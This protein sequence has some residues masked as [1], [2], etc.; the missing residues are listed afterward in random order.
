ME[1]SRQLETN[2]YRYADGQK[3]SVDVLRG[4]QKLTTSVEV[5]KREDDPMRF[6]DLVDPLKNLVPKLGI[7]G[8]AIDQKLAALLPD[9]RNPYGIVVAA[10]AGDSH[11][12]G[13]TLSPGDV[14]YSVNTVAVTSIDTLNKAIDALD[15]TDSLVLQVERDGHLMYVTLELQ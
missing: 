1:S 10:H 4:K 2:L 11:Y 5:A 12:G 8:I 13:D 14:I 3:I 9:L 15:E 7:L 6:A